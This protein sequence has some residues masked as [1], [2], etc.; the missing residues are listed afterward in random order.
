MSLTLPGALREMDEGRHRAELYRGWDAGLAAGFAHHVSLDQIGRIRSRPTEAVR[1]HLIIG[2]QQG[3][4]VASLVRARPKLFAPFDAAILVACEESGAFANSLRLLADHYARDYRRM[5]RIRSQMAYPIFFGVVASFV[6]GLPFLDRGGWRAYLAAIGGFLLAFMLMGG[7]P[8][9]IIAGLA[10]GA[11][12]FARARFVRTLVTALE[13]GLPRGRSV[14]LA[15][16]AS[17]SAELLQH[18]ARRSERELATVPLAELFAACGTVSASLLSQMAVA[19]AAGDYLN[20]LKRY[21][22]GMA[23]A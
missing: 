14:R 13:A 22:E 6:L 21:A 2:S 12:R 15:V 18:V 1:R 20:T 19:D 10:S 17:G 9:S 4:T 11:R 16:D 7:L 5:L 23:D 8:V 3:R